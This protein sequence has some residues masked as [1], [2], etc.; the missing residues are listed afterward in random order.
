[1]KKKKEWK[2]EETGVDG[3]V[4]HGTQDKPGYGSPVRPKVNTDCL[5]EVLF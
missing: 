3:R 5:K 4:K 2:S 1:M